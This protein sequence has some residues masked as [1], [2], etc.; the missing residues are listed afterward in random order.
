MI[1]EQGTRTLAAS[2]PDP[3]IFI[4]DEFITEEQEAKI[5]E[6]LEDSTPRRF[7]VPGLPAFLRWILNP[8]S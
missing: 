2:G 1:E 5:L 7:T 8:V 3:G 6:N 4:L